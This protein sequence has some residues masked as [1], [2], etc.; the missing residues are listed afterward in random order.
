MDTAELGKQL[1]QCDEEKEFYHS[2][3][4]SLLILL[5]NFPLDLKEID[6]PGFLHHLDKVSNKIL[7][8]KNLSKTSSFFEN[9]KKNISTFITRHKTVLGERESEFKEIMMD[10]I[11][12][13]FVIQK[14]LL[15]IL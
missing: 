9:S 11:I 10:P 13:F 15:L 1:Q 14:I 5:K 7:E 3:V 2:A 4:Q 6:T 8:E 12:L